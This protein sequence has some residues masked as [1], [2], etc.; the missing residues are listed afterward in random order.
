[1]NAPANMVDR[2]LV[3]GQDTPAVM[4]YRH[5]SARLAEFLTKRRINYET[6]PFQES[7]QLIRFPGL[8]RDDVER[9]LDQVHGRR[10]G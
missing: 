2:P 4:M 7:F 10:A 1:M 5:Y 3:F 8:S 6:R 9:L